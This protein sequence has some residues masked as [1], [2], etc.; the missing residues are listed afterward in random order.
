MNIETNILRV[1]NRDDSKLKLD[2]DL[3]LKEDVYDGEFFPLVWI[4]DMFIPPSAIINIELDLTGFLPNFSLSI[5]N[6]FEE[7]SS[8]SM[9][10]KQ[11]ILSIL[12]R[13]EASE[14]EPI[15]ANF[16]IDTISAFTGSVLLSGDLFIPNFENQICVSFNNK[17][18]HEVLENIALELGLGFATN[19]DVT[20]DKQTWIIPF[21]RYSEF[22]SKISDY[23]YKEESMIY[24]EIFIDI[25]YNL[26][27]VNVP[28]L[29]ENGEEDE[30]IE[31]FVSANRLSEYETKI[32]EED[33]EKKERE[34]EPSALFL[35]NQQDFLGN[36]NYFE[37]YDFDNQTGSIYK[38]LGLNKTHR[39]FDLD[40]KVYFNHELSLDFEKDEDL[41]ES[42]VQDENLDNYV[43]SGVIND[44]HHL[45]YE[46]VKFQTKAVRAFY[47]R[48]SLSFLL[49]KANFFLHRYLKLPVL[50]WTLRQDDRD[51]LKNLEEAQGSNVEKEE[52][53]SE[54]YTRGSEE[55][56]IL[57]KFVSGYYALKE[58]RL[59]WNNGD[60]HF[61]QECS[62]IKP[63]YINVVN[64]IENSNG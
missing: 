8:I 19:D 5:S 60:S 57:N 48:N 3:K 10:K 31:T 11:D 23:I 64:K 17:T 33:Y 2:L 63:L 21:R 30:T 53:E 51:Y 54:N 59:G 25:Y 39:F 42:I 26:N 6:D 28:K 58:Y 62:F 20:N 35:T 18:S 4:N 29:F 61:Y 32:F 9:P 24:F 13:D 38:S 47:N 50:I 52:S 14:F 16:T 1:I 7:F 56:P 22:L 45:N 44:N 41:G 27:L 55:N 43:W 36:N 46:W 15:K 40:E 34:K 49:N 12:I 37:R